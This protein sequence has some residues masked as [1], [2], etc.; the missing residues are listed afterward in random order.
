MKTT[1]DETQEM[2]FLPLRRTGFQP[3]PFE[4][5]ELG[6]RLDKEKE[7]EGERR[8]GGNVMRISLIIHV[9]WMGRRGHSDGN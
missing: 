9:K 6:K 7:G 4:C 2:S 5:H 8:K 3:I 1:M